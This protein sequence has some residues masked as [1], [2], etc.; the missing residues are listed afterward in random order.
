MADQ[1]I[2]TGGGR[3]SAVQT[4]TPRA[5]ETTDASGYS[6]EL[7][8]RLGEAMSQGSVDSARS[9]LSLQDMLG[10]GSMVSEF[11]A[12]TGPGANPMNQLSP[13]SGAELGKALSILGQLTGTGELGMAGNMLGFGAGVAN[14]P[15]VE[16]QL[17]SFLTG[18]ASFAGVPHVG[19]VS[20]AVR[21][22]M[23]GLLDAGLYALN[24]V[25]GLVNSLQSLFTDTTAGGKIAKSVADAR[26]AAEFE[27]AREAD[28]AIGLVN[29]VERATGISGI[30]LSDLSRQMF[31]GIDIG[32]YASESSS[33][34]V[35][36]ADP[37]HT[38]YGDYGYDGTW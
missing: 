27:T 29:D 23:S 37:G 24:P 12:P 30:G 2:Y 26:T 17:Q 13:Q 19:L 21:G 25:L 28:A 5:V 14:Q 31:D 4:F 1:K 7:L 6:E 35:V 34:E 3:R 18:A 22:N 16:K 32:S 15:N 11:T 20:N 38:D 36:A 33:S 8:A 9:Q 10:S